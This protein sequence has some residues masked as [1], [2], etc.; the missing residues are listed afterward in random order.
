LR[1]AGFITTI[2]YS[3]GADISAACGQLVQRDNRA[4]AQHHA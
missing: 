3:L 2:R 4:L 1:S